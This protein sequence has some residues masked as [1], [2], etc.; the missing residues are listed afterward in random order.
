MVAVLDAPWLKLYRRDSG[1]G[2]YVEYLTILY[3]RKDAT[4][5]TKSKIPY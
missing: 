3:P 2:W 4:V 1:N 5:G